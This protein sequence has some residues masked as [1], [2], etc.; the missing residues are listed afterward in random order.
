MKIEDHRNHSSW[1]PAAS[2]LEEFI[3][4]F[5]KRYFVG[6]KKV[7][8]LDYD[9]HKDKKRKAAARYVPVKGTKLANIEMYLGQY[10]DLPEEARRSRM[11]IAWNI[12]LTLA[13]ELYHHRIR[14][15]RK[16]RKPKF[17]QEQKEADNWASKIVK[18][19][20][21]KEYPPDPHRKEWNLIEQK[22]KENLSTKSNKTI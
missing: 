3:P 16:R 12:L 2:I 7:I 21:I 18:P 15:Q 11:F 4:R 22:I 17:T 1:V 13:H 9:Y 20:F 10:N 5:D 19:I 8:L 14:G 6:I